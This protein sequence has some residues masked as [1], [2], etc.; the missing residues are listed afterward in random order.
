ML[1]VKG[2]KKWADL[3][4][5]FT[6]FT[7]LL[8]WLKKEEFNGYIQLD[9]GEDQGV[10]LIQEGDVIKGLRNVPEGRTSDHA[11]LNSLLDLARQNHEGQLTIGELSQVT[12][13]ILMDYFF[14]SVEVL[15]KGL[16]SEF[17][18]FV[19]FVTQL[20]T[21]K[22]HGYV[23]LKELMGKNQG[24]IYLQDGRIRAIITNQI[25]FDLRMDSSSEKHI[26]ERY[27]NGMRSR[28]MTYDVYRA[29]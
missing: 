18:D 25:L 4:T 3:K 29:S 14:I 19:S 22:F 16:S 13:E 27:L 2:N 20:K 5:A 12:I 7:A 23:E 24:G 26:I 8:K 1:P 10:I 15:Q 17:T 6:D 9:F 11:S 21:K 28:G